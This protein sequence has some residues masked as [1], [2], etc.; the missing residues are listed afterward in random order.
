MSFASSTLR[1]ATLAAH[2]QRV[3][4]ILAQIETRLDAELSLAALAKQAHLSP[5]HFQRVFTAL[6]GESPALFVRRLRLERAARRLRDHDEP[7]RAVASR[8]GYAETAPFT[9]AFRTQFG[10]SPL[11]LRAS[12]RERGGEPRRPGA[13]RT[14]TNQPGPGGQ[15]CYVPMRL[16]DADER[17]GPQRVVIFWPVRIA[18]L[19][20]RGADSV[21][22]EAFGRLAAFAGRSRVSSVPMFVR[23][24]HD[25][26]AL[27]PPALRRVDLGVV[28]G[29][30]RRGEADIGVRTVGGGEHA[31]VTVAGP[32]KS[33]AAARSWL[34]RVGIPRLGA[35]R[36][37][38]PVIEVPL[39]DPTRRSVPAGARLTD[40]L[41]PIV[42][43]H[44]PQR[45]YWRRSWPED[46]SARPTRR[47]GDER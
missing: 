17:P 44:T 21:A 43:E 10:C 24:L 39:H 42:A 36:R 12:A 45:W 13:L 20:Q 34:V 29:P 2:Q 3:L 4:R 7:V 38:G 31:L 25:D 18:W 14:W 11:E 5:F 1:P 37:E 47:T 26:D 16:P 32:E 33:V 30:R 9:R 8:A 23:V 6:V 19:R 15:L 27:T 40:V 46:M 35:T 41:V 22:S 28:I